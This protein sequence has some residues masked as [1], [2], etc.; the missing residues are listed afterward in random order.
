M[1]LL[2]AALVKMNCGL[3]AVMVAATRGTTVVPPNTSRAR[4]YVATIVTTPKSRE[5]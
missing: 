4:K 3:K 5:I 1:S 2:T